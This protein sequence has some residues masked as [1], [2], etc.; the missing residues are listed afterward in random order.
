MALVNGGCL[1]YTDI[2]K[3][4]LLRDRWPNFEIISYESGFDINGCPIARFFRWATG[5]DDK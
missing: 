1:Q 5:S 2:L 4:L 3:D